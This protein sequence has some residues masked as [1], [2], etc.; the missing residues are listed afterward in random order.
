[1]NFKCVPQSRETSVVYS[2]QQFTF[3]EEA[4]AVLLAKRRRSLSAQGN[5]VMYRLVQGYLAHKKHPPLGPYRMTLPRV[6]W[7]SWGG[8]RFLMSEVPLYRVASS[9]GRERQ[10][11]AA[12]M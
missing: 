1:M 9:A 4:P 5:A 12:V 6:L 3:D 11:S 2:L 8:G 7:W 10:G